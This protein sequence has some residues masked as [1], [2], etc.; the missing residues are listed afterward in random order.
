MCTGGSGDSLVFLPVNGQSFVHV[1]VKNPSLLRNDPISG[2]CLVQS[3]PGPLPATVLSTLSIA[4]ASSA[5][6]C[7]HERVDL[8]NTYSFCILSHCTALHV[9]PLPYQRKPGSVTSQ[10][11]FP[12]LPKHF[13]A[14]WFPHLRVP[15]LFILL[16]PTTPSSPNTHARSLVYSIFASRSLPKIFR[17]HQPRTYTCGETL[18]TRAFFFF[19][20]ANM[21]SWFFYFFLSS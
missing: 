16:I 6:Q 13:P 5:P 9:N 7:G 20:R 19:S 2:I 1:H 21:I 17:A 8:S 14:I 12:P 18:V 10:S 4:G 3:K 15:A 11:T